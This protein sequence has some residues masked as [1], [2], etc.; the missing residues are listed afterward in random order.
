MDNYIV[1]N[2]KKAELTEEQLEKLRIKVEKKNPF[3][4]VEEGN[5]YWRIGSVN[6]TICSND[7]RHPVDNRMY[8]NANYFNDESFAQQVAWHEELNRRLLRFAYDHKAVTDWT[9]IRNKKYYISYDMG[10]RDFIIEST[11]S[12]KSFNIGFTSHFIAS[13]AYDQIVKPFMAEHPDFVW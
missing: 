7:A 9:D 8:D 6:N 4:R 10:A 5:R 1:I 11:F 13:K 2:R 3:D 12:S